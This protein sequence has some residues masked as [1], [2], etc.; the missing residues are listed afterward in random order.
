MSKQSISSLVGA[1]LALTVL[2]CRNGDRTNR[3]D[4]T[5]PAGVPP[6]PYEASPPLIESDEEIGDEDELDHDVDDARGPLREVPRAGG[7][8]VEPVDPDMP[9]AL[10]PGADPKRP[11][12]PSRQ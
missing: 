11:P 3:P 10:D 1:V 7:D 2:G 5:N 9:E 12:P 4:D 6:T 8:E